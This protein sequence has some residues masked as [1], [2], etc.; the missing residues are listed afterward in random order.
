MAIKVWIE[1]GVIWDLQ[2]L[3]AEGFRKIVA[4]AKKDVF[5][6]SGRE[7]DHL[8]HS[9]HYPGLAWD[10]R[11]CGLKRKEML[12]ILD[13]VGNGILGNNWTIIYYPSWKG[14]HIQ[15]RPRL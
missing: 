13:D 2:P 7:G 1:Q 5:V 8:P 9:F 10:M 15:Y 11:S 4:K 12:D 14:Y 6:T 3:A